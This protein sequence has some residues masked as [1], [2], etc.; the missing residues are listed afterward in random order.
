MGN[1]TEYNDGQEQTH[2]IKKHGEI[3]HRVGG[4]KRGDRKKEK[5][6]S[7]VINITG[8]GR[9]IGCPSTLLKERERKK[10]AGGKQEQKGN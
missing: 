4:K 7:T 2:Q 3:C 10:V 9:W 6:Q 8:T 1:S 5:S